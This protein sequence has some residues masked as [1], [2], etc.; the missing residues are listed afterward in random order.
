MKHFTSIFLT[1]LSLSIYIQNSVAQDSLSTNRKLQVGVFFSPDIC[2]RTLQN[3]GGSSTLNNEE[4]D[5]WINSSNQLEIPKVSFTAGINIGYQ[6]NTFLG[7]ET[8]VHYS[9]KGYSTKMQSLNYGN[10]IDASRGFVYQ[11]QPEEPTKLKFKYNF[12]YLD[13]PLKLNIT[14][15][16]K[17]IAF[18][19][20]LGVISSLLVEASTKSVSEYANGDKKRNTEKSNFEYNTF[21]ISP[22]I[23]AG[24]VYRINTRMNLRVEPSFQYGMLKIVDTPITAHLYSGGL[25]ISYNF[26]F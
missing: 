22:C 21:N 7:I 16:K 14:L 19:S 20:S 6:V 9:N 18:I 25:N 10:M 12:E 11:S 4:I 24:I 3:N 13:I 23:S 17:K 8:G 15:G 26:L 5:G 1:F 2:Y